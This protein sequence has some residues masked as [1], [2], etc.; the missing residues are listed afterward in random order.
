MT[1]INTQLKVW[2]LVPAGGRGERFGGDTPKQ[3]AIAA[4]KP[5]LAWT[6]AR[7][8]GAGLA[9]L[10][11]ALPEDWLH[12]MPES[13]RLHDDGV[14]WVTGGTNRQQSVAA[15][16]A[17]C[18]R[19]VDLVLVHDG[20]RPAV[21]IRDVA[22]TIAAVGDD[23]GAVLGRP[24]V[25]TL[26]RLEAGRVA[27]TV[28]RRSLFRAETPQVFRRDVL[29]RAVEACARDGFVGTDEAAIVE[30]LEGVR[31][32]AAMATRPNPKLTERQDLL[33]IE[34]LLQEDGNSQ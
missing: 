12:A 22:A 15:C 31:I 6:V 5:I 32:N 1:G 2:G 8:L 9:G 3:L 16:L 24:V 23:D 28:D 14:S 10:T 34:L 18:P 21:S 27:E 11:V 4:G 19:D 7:L 26:K 13:L 20:A 29:V 25:D 30:R 33:R 17:T